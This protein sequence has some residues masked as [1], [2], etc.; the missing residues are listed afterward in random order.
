MVAYPVK[1]C[2]VLLNSTA[3]HGRSC[4]ST[5]SHLGRLEDCLPPVYPDYTLDVRS[6]RSTEP[7]PT[8]D[9]ATS[10]VEMRRCLQHCLVT[11]FSMDWSKT[12]FTW[13]TWFTWLLG[14]LVYKTWFIAHLAS[15]KH[16]TGE[17]EEKEEKEEREGRE[18]EER[19]GE[20]EA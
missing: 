8:L 5:S 20:E 2:L 7:S 3:E 6:S 1:G 17:E 11:F 4:I 9:V 12:W 18:K 16:H 14:Y 15:C 10:R 13:F 19:E